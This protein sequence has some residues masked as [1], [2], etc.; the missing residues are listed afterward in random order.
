VVSILQE[1]KLVERAA[2]L[3]AYLLEALQALQAKHP[4]IQDVRGKGLM[5]GLELAENRADKGMDVFRQLLDWGFI[6][7]Y[8]PHTATFR[9]FPPYVISAEE[10][11]R[12]LGAFDASLRKIL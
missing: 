5:L 6:V 2:A 9:L 10:I 11:D 4:C 1:E 12:F 8:Q 3:G 7:D